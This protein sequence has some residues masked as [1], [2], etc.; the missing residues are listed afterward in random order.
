MR[1]I[2]F[3][4][5]GHDFR[6]SYLTLIKTLREYCPEVRLLG[7]TATASQSVLED[8]KNEVQITSENIKAI[9]SMDRNELVFKRIIVNNLSDKCE[10]IE[11]IIQDLNSIYKTDITQLNGENT[12]CGLVFTPLINS[13]RC[14]MKGCIDV[15]NYLN[16][17]ESLKDKVAVYHGK[18]SATGKASSQNNFMNNKYAILVCTK[19]FG[20]GID[21]SN[22]RYTIHYALPS[23]MEAFYQEAGRAG[24]DSDK[25]KKS[26]CYILYT[27]ETC[28][29]EQIGEIFDQY[30]TFDRRKELCENLHNDLGTNMFLW[31]MNKFSIDDEYNNIY[32]ILK[33]LYKNEYVLTFKSDLELITFQNSLYRLSII[34]IVEDWTIFYDTMQSG[35]L[36]IKYININD[37][38]SEIIDKARQNLNNYIKKYDVEFTLDELN[39]Q[40]VQKKVKSLEI[41]IKFL[42]NWI[43]KNIMYQHIESARTIMEACDP[44]VSDAEFRTRLDYY[45]RFTDRSIIFE[46]L[47]Y[48]PRDYK[49]WFNVLFITNKK[50]KNYNKP[51]SK[52]TAIKALSSLQRYIE[53]YRNNTGFMYLNGMLRFL[54]KGPGFS[55]GVKHLKQSFEVIKSMNISDIDEIITKTLQFAQCYEVEEKDI[56]SKIILDYFPERSKECFHELLDRYSLS[57]ELEKSMNKLNII[58]KEFKNGLFR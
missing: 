30:T 20:M 32:S 38:I 50:S 16:S 14:G 9:T 27:P 36:H 56:V 43:N 37:D 46:N 7:L 51:I 21:K 44:S 8:L 19:A 24:R 39:N 2:A 22:I 53:S 10:K 23:S 11:S 49:N 47:I 25:T 57:I 3:R 41:I 1:F 58:K 17:L 26:Y 13:N 4:N 40:L 33:K 55:E 18:L 35:S 42:L 12:Y 28:N 52:S 54:V 34:G 15:A 31:N 29:K 45:F 5:G 6:V 48:H